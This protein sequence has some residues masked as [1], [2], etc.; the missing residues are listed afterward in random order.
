M[1]RLTDEEKR[2]PKVVSALTRVDLYHHSLRLLAER[3][4]TSVGEPE[5]WDVAAEVRQRSLEVGEGCA[6]MLSAVV[7][8]VDGEDRLQVESAL[9]RINAAL[10][11]ASGT[12]DPTLHTVNI[13]KV[14]QICDELLSALATRYGYERL[15]GESVAATS[16]DR[17]G[18]PSELAELFA[19]YEDAMGGEPELDIGPIPPFEH[20][21]LQWLGGQLYYVQRVEDRAR[22]VELDPGVEPEVIGQ[23]HGGVE[24]AEART[25]EGY[26]LNL[27]LD[28]DLNEE[29][30]R[31][32]LASQKG[33]EYFVSGYQV[34]T[35]ISPRTGILERRRR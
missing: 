3:L 18:E 12:A 28:A 7:D 21:I 10:G 14:V 26:P 29:A 34:A 11:R 2:G 16:G 9:E 25:A 4:I 15:T 33:R 19:E 5:Q 1:L 27:M 20:G 30:L 31:E 24:I 17:G 32:Y 35:E 23:E 13:W 6:E 8:Y 22:W